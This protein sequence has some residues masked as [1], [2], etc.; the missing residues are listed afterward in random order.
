M[1]LVPAARPTASPA[2]ASGQPTGSETLPGAPVGLAR[3]PGREH[4]RD[5]GEQQRGHGEVVLGGARLT[6]D[7]DVALEQDRDGDD[8][9]V[10]A[11]VGAPDAP[12]GEEGDRQPAVVDEDREGVA[13]G[14]EDPGRVQQLRVL[15]V[16]PVGEDRLG[17]MEAGDGVALGDFRREGHVVPERVEVEHASVQGGV[18]GQ[19]PVGDHEGDHA[20]HHDQG[21]G[22]RAGGAPTPAG[23]AGRDEPPEGR[24]H[25]AI[26]PAASRDETTRVQA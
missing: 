11:A 16:E 15:G 18:C 14:D 3:R 23:F 19:A 24:V 13:V 26:A 17:M 1:T 7:Q 25:Q 10:A 21:Q 2:A 20:G 4:D 9:Q 6:H 8:A 5:S 22:V 12:G